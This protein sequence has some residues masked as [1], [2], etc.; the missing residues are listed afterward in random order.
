M[1]SKTLT[2]LAVTAG[3]LLSGNLLAWNEGGGEE[4]QALHLKG[5]ADRGRDVYEICSACHEPEGWG[6]KDGTFPELAGQHPNVLIKELADIRDNRRANSLMYPFA[7]PSMIG[8]PQALAD[9]VAYISRLPMNPDPGHGPGTDLV[10]G[11][12]LYLSRCARC[13]GPQGEGNN[14]RFFPRLQYQ[15]YNYLVREF[16]NIKD[17]RRRNAN[18][19]MVAQIQ[20]FT[21]RDISAVCDYVSRL[22]P[23]QSM[24]APAGWKNPDFQGD[25]DQD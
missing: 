1:I 7:I 17:G 14:E 8:G 24:I 19:D 25:Q 6:L 23:P 2:A 21:E 15:H 9:V 18:P 4:A 5:N 22:R 10:Y 20:H 3:M 16:H 12:Q 13:H 11:R